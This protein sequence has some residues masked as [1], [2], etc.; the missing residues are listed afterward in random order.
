MN[1]ESGADHRPKQLLSLAWPIFVEQSLRMLVGVISTLVVS[2]ISDGA[3]AALGVANQILFFFILSFNFIGVGS[4]VVL[5]HYLGARDRPGA[6]AIARSAIVANTWIG[7]AFSLFVF[8]LAPAL[9][10]GMNLP[11]VLLGIASPFLR[12]MGGSLCLE[13]FNASIAGVLRAHK[14]TRPVMAIGIAQ[15]AVNLGLSLIFIYGWFG[16]P[17]LGVYGVAIAG[18]VSRICASVALSYSLSERIKFRLAARD[19]I[20]LDRRR[21]RSVLRIGLPAA[22]ENVCYWV[23]FMFVT[24]QVATLGPGQLAAQEYTMQIQCFVIMFTMAIALANEIMVGHFVGAGR[25]DSAYLRTL[26]SVRMGLFVAFGAVILVALATPWLVGRFTPDRGIVES[27]SW[28]TRIAIVLEGG[29]VFNLIVINAL[30]ATGDAK[31]PF[32]MAVLSMWMVW[33]P[34]AWGAVHFGFGLPGVWAAMTAD[35]WIRG[36]LMLHRWRKR[37]W[38]PSAV[39]SFQQV[40]AAGTAMVA[41]VQTG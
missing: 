35:E 24:R 26:A 30:R 11:A 29:R 7:I 41:P 31:F 12:I 34:M 19:F 14:Q 25:L 10:H 21:I 8:F 32:R 17:V 36:L 33:V 5:T 28:L 4:S 2:H 9:L 15:N 1:P 6:D 23:A 22:A 13:A 20:A 18:L 38:V 37:K 16:A 39:R 40:G 3:V 27:C